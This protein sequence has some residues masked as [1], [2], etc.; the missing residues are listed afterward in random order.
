MR[1]LRQSII[2][3]LALAHAEKQAFLSLDEIYT[4]LHKTSP[5][6]EQK[7]TKIELLK[8]LEL[9]TNNK[10]LIFRDNYYSLFY[11]KNYDDYESISE[12]KIRHAR[13]VLSFISALP[14]VRCIAISG[15][16]S[17]RVATHES[18]TDIILLVKKGY[19]WTA[20]FLSLVVLELA[21][22][23]RNSQGKSR[24]ICLNFILEEN[25]KPIIQ[26]VASANMFMHA[27]PIFGTEVFYDFIKNNTWIHAFLYPV[28][29]YDISFK[30]YK[31]N[32]FFLS[33]SQRFFEFLLHGAVGVFFEK[34]T[35]A[36]QENRLKKYTAKSS[37]FYY[38]DSIIAL[39]QPDSKNEEVMKKY[40]SILNESSITN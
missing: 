9:L 26:N 18:D 19:L 20:R 40:E 34:K 32:S 8:E 6:H 22:R 30:K 11:V 21:Q 33:S 38:S 23:R 39:H 12:S 3:T 16:V 4:Y 5:N 31:I 35:R 27:L 10:T 7:P 25:A 36:W 1:T 24:K 28:E 37:H 13:L 15:S 29:A 17:F 2:S 14:F